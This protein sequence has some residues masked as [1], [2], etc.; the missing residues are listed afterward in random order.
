MRQLLTSVLYQIGIAAT[1]AGTTTLTG[2]HIDTAGYEDVTIIA[3]LGAITSTG[4]PTL[5]A[6]QG[7]AS[8]GGD[9]VDIEGSAV[10]GADT[11][12][13]K[14]LAIEIHRPKH[15]YITPVL[16][17]STANIVVNNV[18]VILSNP[19]QVPVTQTLFVDSTALVTPDSG[20][21]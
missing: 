21:A 15:R 9:A 12:S 3:N 8:D 17:R 1:A 20:T 18:I 16:L 14:C 19:A 13:G 2:S 6:Q 4:V 11:D 10:V 5:K 7:D